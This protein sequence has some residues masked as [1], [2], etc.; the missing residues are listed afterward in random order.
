M[1]ILRKGVRVEEY[2]CFI[3]LHLF[4]IIKVIKSIKTYLFIYP[5]EKNET[6]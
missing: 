2:F 4:G 1:I 6:Y 5:E 3:F